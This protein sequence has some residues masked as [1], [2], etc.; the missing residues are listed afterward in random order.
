MLT[1]IQVKEAVV[2][3][4]DDKDNTVFSYAVKDLDILVNPNGLLTAFAAVLEHITNLTT[5][6]E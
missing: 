4:L 6:K 2:T 5:T 3:V 1:S